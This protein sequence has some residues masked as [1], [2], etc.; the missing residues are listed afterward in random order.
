MVRFICE[1]RESISHRFR[2]TGVRWSESLEGKQQFFTKSRGHEKTS[3]WQ[4][5]KERMEEAIKYFI[6]ERMLQ[7]TYYVWDKIGGPELNNFNWDIWEV[8][9][10]SQRTFLLEDTMKCMLFRCDDPQNWLEVIKVQIIFSHLNYFY[11]SDLISINLNACE[12]FFKI[13]LEI[14]DYTE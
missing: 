1:T 13:R 3:T 10:S 2:Q 14:H 5:S 7:C 9:F 6:L 8:V 4:S 12:V 11:L